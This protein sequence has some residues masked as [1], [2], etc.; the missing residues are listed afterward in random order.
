[1]VNT[2]KL[3]TSQTANGFEP[4]APNPVVIDLAFQTGFPHSLQ[5]L[6]PST[7]DGLP[8]LTWNKSSSVFSAFP[9]AGARLAEW[10]WMGYPILH[11]PSDPDLENIARVRGG[12]PILF[13]F[14]GRSHVDGN[15]GHWTA[16]D[17]KTLPMPQHGFVR[18]GKT[19]LTEKTDEGFAAE[20]IPDE[21]AS[22][23]YPFQHRFGIDYRF[24]STR[25]RVR[26]LLEN[27]GHDP[28]PW[29]PGHHFY[30][31]L[32]F[33][34]NFTRRDWII[35]HASTAAWRHR[36][37][38]DFDPEPAPS[39]L[40]FADASISNRILAATGNAPLKIRA[41]GAP[42]SIEI[43]ATA[44][45]PEDICTVLWTESPDSP[46]YCIEPWYGLPNGSGDGRRRPTVP[47]GTAA[48]FTVTVT[49]IPV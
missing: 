22:L 20:W 40:S 14:A 15:P 7:R 10:S 35:E 12:N 21:I 45:S 13:P 5:M 8:F 36:D 47:P 17:G 25:L 11:W 31:A 32:P 39:P 46:F 29:A 38:G 37:D 19:R 1:M 44:D 42:F 9:T 24:D 26:L 3:Q 4:F 18:S 23:A 41:E 49:I 27:L 34:E 48:S 6:Q 30:F 28:I 33:A 43:V 2:A 16:P